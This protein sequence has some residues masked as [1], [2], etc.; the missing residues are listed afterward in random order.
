MSETEDLQ[1]ATEMMDS[2][3]EYSPSSK[4]SS[5][6]DFLEQLKQVPIEAVG[7][8]GS[9]AK[10]LHRASENVGKMKE[11]EMPFIPGSE[12]APAYIP[13]PEVPL[14]TTQDVAKSLNYQEPQTPLG[15]ITKPAAQG[16]GAGALTLNPSAAIISAGGGLAKGLAQEVLGVSEETGDIVDLA[17][18]LS[19]G[20]LAALK[21][22]LKPSGLTERYFES[23]KKTLNMPKSQYESLISNIEKESKD[24]IEKTLSKNPNYVSLS[25]N[26][27][28]Y[29]MDLDKDLDKV[30]NLAG[31]IP[32]EFKAED[33]VK[34][35]KKRSS[36]RKYTPIADSS[37][38]KAYKNKI[39]E[40]LGDI[41]PSEKLPFDSLLK[42]YRANNKDAAGMFSS[43]STGSELT[44]K[45]D[46]L[47]DI[48]R[49]LSDVMEQKAKGSQ[50]NKLFKLTNKRF[51]D[52]ANIQQ[53]ND[54]VSDIFPGDKINYRKVHDY[55]D[56]GA[57]QR[58]ALRSSFGKDAEAGFSR[59]MKDLLE[60]ERGMRKI[61]PKTAE[62]LL[63]VNGAYQALKPKEWHR[64]IKSYLMSLPVV[65]VESIPELAPYIGA[66]GAEG[67]AASS[68]EKDIEDLLGD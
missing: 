34:A 1:S 46:A 10:T 14:P 42:K 41:N 20:S 11:S 62:S 21:R 35:I 29:L 64:R 24:I 60:Q 25:E 8:P 43:A 16:L 38:D 33:V 55:F 57:V 63:T 58:R 2:L 5:G 13:V 47:L 12:F 4:M 36:S 17:T 32:G 22:V 50:Y 31:V 6:R 37:E 59:L 7:G 66:K 30:T 28:K 44:G 54:F 3:N 23:G 48:N 19:A 49:A 45:R 56:K 68:K 39:K 40:V 27:G 52:Q 61:K 15:R 67:A 9:I 18:T 51:S 53:I 65:D 26:P